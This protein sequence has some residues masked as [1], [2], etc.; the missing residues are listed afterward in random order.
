VISHTVDDLTPQQNGDTSEDSHVLAPTDDQLPVVTV[1]HL[2]SFQTPMTTTSYEDSS[3]IEE[4]YVRDAHHGHVDP[5]IQEVQDVRTVDLTHIDP[6]EEIESQLLET[7]LVEQIVETDRLMEHLP[8]GSVYSDED[9]LLV[10]RDDHNTCLDTSMW[11]PCADDSSRVSAQEY[12]AAHTGYN[13][14]QREIASSDGM[15]WHTG[16]LSSTTD[17]GQFSTLS[18]AESIFG[19]SRVDTSRTD[20]SSEGYEVAPQHDFDQESHHLAAQ[21]RVTE[22]MIMAATRRSDDMH[23]LMADYCWRESVA[24][25]SSDE[26]FALDDFHTLRERV[27]VMRTDY[28]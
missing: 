2:S 25:G 16:G 5:Q 3:S 6:H 21:L 20:T 18:Y 8:P 12:T 24:H 11:D 10:S 4:P 17:S 26:G 1:T 7:P 27:S 13:V 19:D 22:D 9:A 28:Q 14:I 23:A 15:Q